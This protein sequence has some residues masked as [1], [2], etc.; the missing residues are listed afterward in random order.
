MAFVKHG[1]II[2]E[3][4][5]GNTKKPILAPNNKKLIDLNTNHL[6]Q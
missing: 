4:F 3:T 6:I 2:S 5:G 1:G